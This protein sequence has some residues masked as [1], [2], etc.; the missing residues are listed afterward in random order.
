MS[1]RGRGNRGEYYKNKYGRGNA[2]RFGGGRQGQQSP[3][4]DAS[5]PSYRAD[6]L[7]SHG[8]AEDLRDSLRR[9]EGQSY[10]RYHDIE[11]S[12]QFEGFT[13]ILD[14]AQSD[15]F[16]QPS[17]CRVQVSPQAALFPRDLWQSLIRR[18]A[19]CDYLTRSFGEAVSAAGADVRTESSG[20]HG[21]KGGEMTVDTPG[22]HVLQRTSCM[23]TDEGGVEA[24]FTVALPARGRTILG[25]WAAQTLVTN[26]PRYVRAGLFYGTQDAEALRRHVDCVEDTDALRKALRGL[27]LV[28]FVGNGSVLPRKSGASDQPMP[29][30]EAVPFVSPPSL[31]VQV[32][33]PRRG[34]VTGMGIRQGVTLI[35]G[36]GFHGKTTLLKALEAGIY[37]KVPGDGRE[38]IATVPD[39]VKVRAEDGR[40]VEATDISPFI[41][42]LPFG[43]DTTMFCTPDASG[44][45][46]QAANI[47]EAL[48]LGSS[49]L[50]LD[51][52]VCATN[53]MIR[54]ARMQA[55]VKKENEPITPFIS[56]IRPLLAR[57]VSSILVMGGSGDYFG[58]SD[59]VLRMACYRAADVT[60]EAHA[61]DQRFGSASALAQ[62]QQSYGTVACRSPV[63]IYPGSPSERVK[64][65]T[66]QTNLIQFG[67]EN[68]DLSGLEQLV[69]K[70]QTRAIAEALCLLRGWIG[71]PH[72]S[73]SSL[74]QLLKRMDAEIDA[75]GLDA[76][77]PGLIA[78]NFARPRVFEIGA[79]LNRLRTVRMEQR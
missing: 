36:G 47:Q 56:K 70:S 52:D 58:V 45:T 67:V 60:T 66:R 26:L 50:L 1:G 35:V 34:V 30:S 10:P 25:Q 78:G 77:A 41:S 7:R 44:S 4:D 23:I 49:C 46:S 17:R 28:A 69:E 65:T 48:E 40:R 5:S 32:T 51:E 8:G 19:L 12:W 61:I 2:G 29:A 14:R 59:T 62:N 43:K 76:L 63:A 74:A 24:R 21:Q 6:Q 39:A 54:D 75:K 42:N 79:A 27:G 13:F 38:L 31:A 22:Q 73:G 20:W 3:D 33:L 15:P 11:G 68:L 71:Q 16:A 55:L 18:T 9:L 53:F 64:T 72:M 37:D 57:G